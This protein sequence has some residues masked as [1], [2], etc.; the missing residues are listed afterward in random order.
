MTPPPI[1][2]SLCLC[3]IH[4]CLR[5]SCCSSNRRKSACPIRTTSSPPATLTP[6][7]TISDECF[8]ILAHSL[9]LSSCSFRSSGVIM[10]SINARSCGLI[11]ACADT[12]VVVRKADTNGCTLADQNVGGAEA[13]NG[14]GRTNWWNRKRVKG[15]SPP[16]RPS[17][18]ACSDTRSIAS[19]LAL[20]GRT[21]GS[22]KRPSAL[23]P[24]TG[25]VMRLSS[26]AIWLFTSVFLR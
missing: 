2:I 26:C 22:P 4:R 18:R 6:T 20:S 19:F 8:S 23:A 5:S 16:I 21:N 7:P 9:F 25:S 3:C 10:L 11:V 17:E 14:K 13:R 24:R 15:R 1:S 12:P